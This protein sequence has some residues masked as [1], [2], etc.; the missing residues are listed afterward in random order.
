SV[1]ESMEDRYPGAKLQG[2][3]DINDDRSSNV[4]SMTSQYAIPNLA[5]ERSGYWL[6]R[7][8]PGNMNGVLAAPPSSTRTTPLQLPVFPYDAHYTFEAT[9][10]AEVNVISVPRVNTV[11]NEYFHYTVRSSFRGND[12]KTAIELATFT[13]RIEPS[14]FQK[15]IEDMRSLANITMG[16]A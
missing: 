4:F 7:F 13:D 6:V 11:A 16:V 12:F 9:C 1:G 14:G 5:V 10:P 15:Y 3:P 8:S 2:E